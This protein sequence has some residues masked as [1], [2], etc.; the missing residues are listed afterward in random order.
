VASFI[1]IVAG[2]NLALGYL[3]ALYLAPQLSWLRIAPAA[4]PAAGPMPGDW[5]PSAEPTVSEPA[6]ERSPAPPSDAMSAA[7]PATVAEAESAAQATAAEEPELVGELIEE[8]KDDLLKYRQHLASLERRM[9]EGGEDQ[10]AGVMQSCLSDLCEAN[11]R[12]LA[13][14]EDSGERLQRGCQAEPNNEPITRQ[15]GAAIDQQTIEVRGANEN[16]ASIDATEASATDRQKIVAETNRLIDAS[17]T[18]RDTLDDV[19]Q[20]L[21]KRGVAQ[22]N[23]LSGAELKE[24]LVSRAE[25]EAALQKRWEADPDHREPLSL[26]LVD[27][28]RCRELN[29]EHG[30]Q[31]ADRVL[32]TVAQLVAAALETSQLAAR[33]NGEKFLLLLS[34]CTGRTATSAL[35]GIRQQIESTQFQAAGRNFEARVSCAAAEAAAGDTVATVIDRLEAT[36]QEAKR[37]GRNRTFF[38]DGK[39]PTPVVP[40]LLALE[41]KTQ[42]V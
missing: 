9:R 2:L 36:L 20:K 4:P 11:A 6:V 13:Q 10:D 17:H 24:R 29:D 12:Y 41:P 18:L 1:F 16:L 27:L 3:L 30:L 34:G 26:G 21:A 38:H 8:F 25:L 39:V 19:G 32:G 28:D 14:T 31:A 22:E 42:E 33:L 35:E 37:Y 7:T 15:L 23:E 5:R 40:P